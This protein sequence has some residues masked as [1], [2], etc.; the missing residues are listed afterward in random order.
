MEAG[1]DAERVLAAD[2][3]ERVEPLAPEGLEHLLHATVDLVGVG[4]RRAEDRAAAREDPGDVAALER[5]D[6]P[7]DQAAP[8]LADPGDLPAEV[9]ARR[10][11]ARMTA[12]RPGQSP[13]PVRI[14]SRFATGRV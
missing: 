11:T 7:F 5:L 12:F 6:D 9:D 1:R 14:P 8:A 4:P 13:P 10:V 3:D 2:R